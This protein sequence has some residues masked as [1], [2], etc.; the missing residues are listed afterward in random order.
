M[1]RG[2]GDGGRKVLEARDLR[3]VR[4]GRVILDVPSFSANDGDVISLIGP[5]GSGKTTFL[6]TLGCLLKRFDGSLVFRGKGIEGSGPV[7]EYRRKIAMVFQ[8]P[9]L[10]NSTVFGNVASGLVFRGVSRQDVKRAVM[11]NLARFGIDHLAHR[12]AR[13]LSGGEAQR[14]S[15]ARAFAVG[16]EVLFLDEPMSALDSPTRE[17]LIADLEE[18]L[19]A[20]K[21][22]TIFATHDR[23]EALRLSR[24]IAVMTGGRIIQEGPPAEIMNRPESEFVAAFMG[25]ETILEGVVSAKKDG[26]LVVATLGQFIEALGDAAENEKVLLCIRPEDVLISRHLATKQ[27]SAR[28]IFSATVSKLLP[29][30]AYHKVVLDCGFPL[31]AFV[32]NQSSAELG[33]GEGMSVTASCKA[34]AIHV[35]RRP[36]VL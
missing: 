27:T 11:D 3:V 24:R 17:S 8:E 9:L 4:G 20:R 22:T 26:L 36:A 21:I 18:A 28:N 34:T 30:G 6:Q 14:T 31:V 10:F 33:L 5:N 12:S 35:I 15:L 23:M 29:M 2:E 13:T 1:N 19:K 25:V 16:P 32:T 7:F